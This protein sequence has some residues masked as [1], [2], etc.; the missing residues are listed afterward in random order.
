M[1]EKN[2]GIEVVEVDGR[3]YDDSNGSASPIVER[4]LKET[5]AENFFCYLVER[6]QQSGNI[7][8]ANCLKII[9]KE[10]TQE[11]KNKVNDIL[12]LAGFS[13]Q[14]KEKIVHIISTAGGPEFIDELRSKGIKMW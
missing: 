4:I 11:Q 12:G 5:A 6:N 1:T 9:S 14:R 10:G 2:N 13:P 7:N 8:C 3:G